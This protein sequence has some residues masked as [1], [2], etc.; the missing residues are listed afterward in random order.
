ML[1]LRLIDAAYPGLREGAAVVRAEAG[2]FQKGPWFRE[3]DLHIGDSRKDLNVAQPS[4]AAR[5]SFFRASFSFDDIGLRR[6]GAF[7]RFVKFEE[8]DAFAR[9]VFRQPTWS[10]AEI[11][12]SLRDRGAHYGPERESMKIE[13]AQFAAALGEVTG[14]EPLVLSAVSFRVP[15]PRERETGVGPGTIGWKAVYSPASGRTDF[16]YEAVYEPFEGRLL[17]LFRQED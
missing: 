9:A 2:V 10:A 14:T 16:V 12:A 7:G 6:Y 13:A 17:W 4:Q 11:V 5:D 15:S 1:G 8:N 3:F